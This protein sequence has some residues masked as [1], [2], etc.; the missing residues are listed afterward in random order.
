MIHIENKIKEV[1]LIRFNLVSISIDAQMEK[2]GR[3]NLSKSRSSWCRHK[4]TYN[5]VIRHAISTLTWGY[6]PKYEY[7]NC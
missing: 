3:I 1:I 7:I 2:Y 4:K 5:K 6:D